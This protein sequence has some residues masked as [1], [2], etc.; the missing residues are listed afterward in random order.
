VGG[1]NARITLNSNIV[2]IQGYQGCAETD[3]KKRKAK[4]QKKNLHRTKV[5]TSLMYV[6]RKGPQNRVD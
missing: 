6:I 3:F 4:H 1:T 2:D 5:G